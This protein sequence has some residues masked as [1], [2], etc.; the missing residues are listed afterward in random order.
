MDELNTISVELNT[1]GPRGFR[2]ERGLP[3]FI[4][5]NIN[6]G[7]LIVEQVYDDYVFVINND[8]E[9]IVRW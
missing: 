7:N 1:A 3:A 4:Q 6:N 5:F 8:G 2:G 9:L